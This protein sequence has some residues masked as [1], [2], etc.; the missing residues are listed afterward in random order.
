MTARM[1][2]GMKLSL[3]AVGRAGSRVLSSLRRFTTRVMS[4]SKTVVTCAAVSIEARMLRAITLRT[5]PSWAV[6]STPHELAPLAV[7]AAGAGVGAAAGA[8][9]AREPAQRQPEARR[10][11]R[12]R[13]PAERPGRRR[14]APPGT[15]R[16]PSWSRA[17]RGRYPGS[18]AMSSAVLGDHACDDRR[19]EACAG[20]AVAVRVGIVV[21]R[22]LGRGRRRCGRR[23][24]DLARRC[25]LGA[26]VPA[27]RAPPPP[28]LPGLPAAGRRAP[29][30][31]RHPSVITAMRVPTSTVSPSATR[32]SRDDAA[33]GRRNLG[34]DLVGRDL[35]DRLVGLDPLAD[36]LAPARDRALRH[37]DA[38]L[39]HYDVDCSSGAHGGRSSMRLMLTG[40]ER[41]RLA[42]AV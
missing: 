33:A 8:G 10:P 4:T 16:R 6:S 34:I 9:E 17:R 13:R 23:R 5:V 27:R 7:A 22:R 41:I 38:H 37:A 11:R 3:D 20:L 1:M 29:P 42:P 12:A 35:D 32:I 30:C 15:A 26:A 40:H 39:G 24:R 18:A 25:G 21:R 2:N 31:P 14:H 28:G 19:H 36:L